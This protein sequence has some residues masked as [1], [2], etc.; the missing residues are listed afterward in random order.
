MAPEGRYPIHPLIRELEE[1]P[2][3]FSFFRAVWL[4]QQAFPE[5]AAL[6][7]LGPPADEATWLRP[8]SS[9]AFPAADVTK[10]ERR[11][12]D[13][14][15]YR[16]TTPI[17]G[18][19]GVLSPLPSF[20]TTDIIDYEM[21]E[22][23]V[24][25]SRIFLDIVNHRLLSF[26]YRAWAKYRW[27]FTF[28]PGAL[29]T[30]SQLLMGWLGLATEGLQERVGVPAG[31]LLRY[32]GA[33]TQKPRSASSVAGV[34]SDYFGEIEVRVEQCVEQWVRIAES[35]RN[36]LGEANASLGMTL[37]IGEKVR[38]R[39]GKCRIEIGPID[40]DRY[41][42][43]RPGGKDHDALCAL[44]RYMLPDTLLYD[45][46]LVVRKETIPLLRLSNGP[47]AGRLGWSSWPS[48]EPAAEDKDVIFAAA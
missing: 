3:R 41:D 4:L 33:V 19:Y 30:T 23:D 10:I 14:A 36:R 9:L 44:A 40:F 7:E 28:E 35:D 24:D 42:T 32:A 34:V 43:L 27:E 21:R 26:L 37:M 20:Y 38:D 31:R 8:S 6:G 18:L 25:P 29:D 22:G 17:M 13:S 15:P 39:M 16:V 48:S 5:A 45:L 12:G 2:Q 11:E 1:Y 47:E 46:R